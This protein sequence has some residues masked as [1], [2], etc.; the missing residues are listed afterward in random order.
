[1]DNADQNPFSSEASGECAPK[2]RCVG[3]GSVILIVLVL[4]GVVGAWCYWLWKSEPTYW[5]EHEKYLQSTTPEQRL[6]IAES[7]EKR[8]F[9]KLSAVVSSGGAGGSSSAAGSGG[10]GSGSAKNIE[11]GVAA[12]MAENPDA[13]H[14]LL[15][16]TEEINAW[17]NQRLDGWASNQGVSIP[18]FIEEPML[19]IEGENLVIAFRF[20]KPPISQVVSLVSR[21]VIKKG[22]AIIQVRGIRG[23]RLRMPGVKAASKAVGSRGGS[24]EFAKAAEKI[25]EVFDGK[26]F[27]PVIKL[28]HKKI[29]MLSF[30][31]QKDGALIKFKA[32]PKKKG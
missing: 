30:V 22:E 2:K 13:V 9:D 8:I 16:T 6:V 4:S 12:A 15:L 25:T 5:V 19:A 3:C 31:L 17:M 11:D 26:A 20:E 32:V 18:D 10:Q 28:N 23:G 29:R 27:D 21:V 1:M 24:S 7:V 14:S